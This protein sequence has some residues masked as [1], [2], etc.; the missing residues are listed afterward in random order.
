M[1]LIDNTPNLLFGWMDIKLN[2][3]AHIIILVDAYYISLEL[4]RTTYIYSAFRSIP[5][6]SAS[7]SK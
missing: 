2:K 1:S 6:I 3:N 5:I 7:A 4:F